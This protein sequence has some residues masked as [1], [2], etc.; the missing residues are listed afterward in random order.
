MTSAA[1]MNGMNG[2]NTTKKKKKKKQPQP[3]S[4]FSRHGMARPVAQEVV[5][6]GWPSSVSISEY[7]VR[8]I[9]HPTNLVEDVAYWGHHPGRLWRSVLN[10]CERPSQPSGST[11]RGSS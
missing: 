1:L 2:K 7:H 5:A 4:C 3:S 9:P 8:I 10:A 6:Q 11:W